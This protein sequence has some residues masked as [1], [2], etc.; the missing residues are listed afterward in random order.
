MNL[1]QAVKPLIKLITL[2]NPFFYPTKERRR[3]IIFSAINLLVISKRG[4]KL[5][6]FRSTVILKY[7]DFYLLIVVGSPIAVAATT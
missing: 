4:F 6:K 3:L 7:G 5:P 2:L 1:I